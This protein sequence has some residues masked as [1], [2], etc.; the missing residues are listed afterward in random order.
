[1]TQ[2]I[3]RDLLDRIDRYGLYV[4][5]RSLSEQRGAGEAARFER[6][7]GDAYREV[8]DALLQLPGSDLREQRVLP[9]DLIADYVPD[10]SGRYRI[11]RIGDLLVTRIGDAV[12]GDVF[13]QR[14]YRAPDLDDD[15]AEWML[16]DTFGAGEAPDD[17]DAAIVWI[18]GAAYRCE[19]ARDVIA[20]FVGES[21]DVVADAVREIGG[22]VVDVAPEATR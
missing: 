14:L 9:S 5:N 15:G 13:E 21:D 8:V 20:R 16:T 2:S 6:L 10:S 18:D 17:V 11:Y 1:M 7:A 4:S 19:Q 12:A 22:S 3:M